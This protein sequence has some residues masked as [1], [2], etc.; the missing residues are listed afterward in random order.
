MSAILTRWWAIGQQPL[1]KTTYNF[2]KT[3]ALI[4]Y[5]EI[6]GSFIEI[7]FAL[8]FSNKV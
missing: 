5:F 1:I 6:S 8:G 7:N 4:L 3:P 2:S